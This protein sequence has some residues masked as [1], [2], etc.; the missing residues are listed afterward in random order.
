MATNNRVCTRLIMSI[1]SALLLA[2]CS[3]A[4]PVPS[5]WKFEDSFSSRAGGWATGSDK[6]GDEWGYVDGKYRI[7]IKVKAR[8]VAAGQ[9]AGIPLAINSN[10]FHALTVEADAV[11]QTGSPE[12][13][14][15]VSCGISPAVWYFFLINLDGYYFIVRDAAGVF[16][17]AELLQS[18][19]TN[20]IIHGIGEINHI[21]AT[22]M[23]GT[24]ETML[25]LS[26]NGQKVADARSHKGETFNPV[27]FVVTTLHAIGNSTRTAVPGVTKEFPG[28]PTAF[29]AEVL[30]DNFVAQVP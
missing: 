11:Q 14:Y 7:L 22:C 23:G 3:V 6:R 9:I 28:S 5:G 15:G 17:G 8:Q 4:V 21:Q 25:T 20:V 26:V 29:E 12:T 16:E 19:R 30:F 13:L 24:Q 18:G 1:L 10:R 2:G 27:A